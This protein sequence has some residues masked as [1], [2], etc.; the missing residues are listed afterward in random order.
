MVKRNINAEHELTF[1]CY[2][3]DPSGLDADVTAVEFPDI[4]VIHPKYWF[5][6]EEYAMGL[7][8]CWDRPKTFIFNSHNWLKTSGRFIFFDLDVII[9]D[10]IEP[11][12][13]Y[14]FTK[15]TML[16]SWWENPENVRNR[17]FIVTHGTIL[18]GS[19]Q[20]WSDDQTECIWKDVLKNQ[21]KIWFT[22][23]GGSDNYHYWRWR[24]LWNTFPATVAYCYNR[25]R[26]WPNDAEVGIYR[27]NC[28]LC[29]FNVDVTPVKMT[30]RDTKKQEHLVDPK[31]LEHWQ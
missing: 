15:P 1:Y 22:F 16:R 17:S 20:V 19:C 27:P 30:D 8:R 5:G 26:E 28:I 21:E 18:N 2:T 3:D 14:D 9:Q 6:K 4:P 29:V 11:L 24:N 23:T 31:L 13:T 12:L 10:N 25:G 7:A